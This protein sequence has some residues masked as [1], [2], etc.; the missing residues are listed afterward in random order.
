[1]GFLLRRT[2][3]SDTAS[4]AALAEA[5]GDL[6]LA[7]EQAAAYLDNTHI[8]PAAYLTLYREHG[9]E[10]LALGEPLTTEQTVA[11]TWQVA[12]DQLRATPG[13]PEL[14][15]LC[16]FLAPDDI[17]RALYG[18]HAEVLPESLGTTTASLGN[19]SHKSAFVSLIAVAVVEPPDSRPSRT[20]PQR[21][22]A[23]RSAAATTWRPPLSIPND[24]ATRSHHRTGWSTRQ[25]A[26]H[27]P[28]PQTCRS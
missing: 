8:T 4:L 22:G 11:T 6:P 1:V 3:I 25:A 23:R 9:A 26:G 2:A 20:R 13:A 14:L 28:R 7:L 12:L 19:C 5:L 27:P 10:L 18:K 17:P 21:G 15:S 24:P 16:A